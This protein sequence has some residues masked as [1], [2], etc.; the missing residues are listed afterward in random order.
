VP[1]EVVAD[2]G[3]VG[4]FSRRLAHHA[5]KV[6]AVDIDA[7]LLKLAEK[8][9]PANVRTIQ[10]TPD[11]PKLDAGS[12]DTVFICDVLHHIE[13]RPAYY[14]RLTKAL[15][16]GGR[17]VVVDFHKKKLP[18]GPPEAMKLSASR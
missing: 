8:N 7:G 11:D 17:I 2:I 12:V 15:K 14:A 4:Y 5:G 16:S 9:A 1:D 3:R 18:V 6:L 10:A 13:N